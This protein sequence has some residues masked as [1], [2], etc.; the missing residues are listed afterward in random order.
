MVVVLVFERVARADLY[1]IMQSV[2]HGP[3]RAAGAAALAARLEPLASHPRAGTRQWSVRELGYLRQRSSLLPL[4][5]ALDDGHE[6]VR[7]ETRRMLEML[8]QVHP[9]AAD[10]VAGPA[11]RRCGVVASPG[12][13][14]C[15]CL[16]RVPIGAPKA[17]R[18]ASGAGRCP[19]YAP[20]PIDLADYRA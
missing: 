9:D 11:E 16:A 1:K 4:I 3:E 18:R 15:A 6:Q 12:S 7:V 20:A 14:K 8:A 13:C 10:V 2:R 5:D 19:G 17:Q